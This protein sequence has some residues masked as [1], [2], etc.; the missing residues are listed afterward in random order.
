MIDISV[1]QTQA[2]N[3]DLNEV[4]TI[5]IQMVE[6]TNTQATRKVAFIQDIKNCTRIK[7]LHQMMWNFALAGE[8]LNVL[9]SRW[10]KEHK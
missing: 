7:S 3:T 6:V 2:A 4:K 5:Y 1:L 9:N 8:K 10:S